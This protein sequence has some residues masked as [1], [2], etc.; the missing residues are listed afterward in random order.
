MG[1]IVRD[2]S[3]E[4]IEGIKEIIKEVEDEDQ[5][6][7][8]DWLEDT[9]IMKDL[10]ISS[11]INNVKDYQKQMI[12]K[13]NMSSKDLDKVIKRVQA[14]DVNYAKRFMHIYDSMVSYNE[15]IK[16]I[17]LMISPR[18]VTINTDMYSSA[19]K[20]IKKRYDRNIDVVSY[21][22]DEESHNLCNLRDVP[23]YEKVLNIAG[24]TV[25]SF[26]GDNIEGTLSLPSMIIDSIFGTNLAENNHRAIDSVEEWI[27]S[28]IAT[29][30]ESFYYGKMI[31][32]YICTAEGAAFLVKGG[33]TLAS[34]FT[35]GAA[36]AGLSATGVGAVVGVPA[37]AVSGAL[38]IEGAVE[39]SVGAGICYAAQGS[40]DSDNVRYQQAES[41]NVDDIKIEDDKEILEKKA[42]EIEEKNSE[43]KNSFDDFDVDTATRKQN[44]NYGEYTADDNIINKPSI[45]DSGYDLK[46]IGRPAPKGPDD[47]LVKGIDGLYKNINKDSNIKYVIDEAKFGK[48]QLGKTKDG[49]QMSNDWLTGTN[50]GRSRILKAVNGDKNLA[51]EITEALK[52]NQ[53]E[54]VL[55]RV[56]RL[57]NVVT[58]RLDEAGKIIGIWP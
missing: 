55:S 4:A 21:H 32:N 41:P 17:T 49:L 29:D 57:G 3:E 47:K 27:K 22:I 48:S 12:D 35:V 5:C 52:Y 13:H 1:S 38:V 34:A 26:I 45:K 51:N 23:W 11:Y 37:L 58:Y 9:F 36:G 19:V 8:F 33:I 46:P 10:D 50:T 42:V 40:S 18:A 7:L 31:G 20:G 15:K 24:G 43:S 44:G 2:F 39:M 54:R 53:V 30:D 16:Q 56:D 14:V 25:T 6:S 28:K